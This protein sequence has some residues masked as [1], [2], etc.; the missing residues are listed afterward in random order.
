M[1]DVGFL[2]LV[3]VAIVGLVVL[4]P[5]RLPHAIRSVMSFVNSAKSMANNVKSEIEH[6]LKVT[7]IK[8]T[9]QTAQHSVND[10]K[11]GVRRTKASLKA[12][13]KI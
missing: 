10:I 4:G 11:K 5:E 9:M 1:F 13:T 8:E 2:E 12:S 3:L 7:E 6:E